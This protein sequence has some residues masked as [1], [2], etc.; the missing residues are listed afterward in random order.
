MLAC[1]SSQY[2]NG[3]RR[4]LVALIAGIP[5]LQRKGA[6]KQDAGTGFI[7]ARISGLSPFFAWNSFLSVGK[8]EGCRAEQEIGVNRRGACRNSITS[9][10]S[11]RTR[12]PFDARRFSSRSAAGWSCRRIYVLASRKDLRVGRRILRGDDT[13]AGRIL[14]GTW[15]LPSLKARL[16][17]SAPPSLI[18]DWDVKLSG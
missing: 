16:R 2:R 11:F 7:V 4:A 8:R 3:E 12:N 5:E 13:T 6:A 17:L 9:L 18:N 15:N 1:H 10:I 14:S